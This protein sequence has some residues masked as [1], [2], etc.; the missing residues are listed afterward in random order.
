MADF[1]LSTRLDIDWM[2][3]FYIEICLRGPTK[4][5]LLHNEL[6]GIFISYLNVNIVKFLFSRFGSI[7]PQLAYT[8]WSVGRKT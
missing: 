7:E 6:T 1:H 8:K 3:E 5:L 4:V 2:F